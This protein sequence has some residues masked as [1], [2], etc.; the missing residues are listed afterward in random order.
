MPEQD[1]LRPRVPLAQAPGGYM[2]LESYS[3]LKRY[4]DVLRDLA[5]R[6]FA[7]AVPPRGSLEQCRRT[8]QGIRYPRAGGL[9]DAEA[10][11]GELLNENGPWALEV[12][13]LEGE[14]QG[15]VASLIEGDREPMRALLNNHYVL[16][17]DLL[18][19]FTAERKLVCRAAAQ[20][21]PLDE[22]TAP[23]PLAMPLKAVRF[24]KNDL[25]AIIDGLA[26]GSIR[27]PG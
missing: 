14:A 19:A 24:S 10:L 20:F 4:W 21:W 17:L 8:V 18:L 12:F 16:N 27:M 15:A 22:V 1:E 13:N 5:S 25:R 6:G 2:T 11:R 26:S 23:L 9:L 7:V 3:S